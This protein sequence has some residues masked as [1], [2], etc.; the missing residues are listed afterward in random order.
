MDDSLAMARQAHL[1]GIAAIC[2]TPHIRDDHDVR[3]DELPARI[4]ALQ[5][6]L[7]AAAIPVHILAG[8]EVAER[9]AE[10]LDSRTLRR[11]ALGAGGWVL[12]EPRPGPLS[13]TLELL[14]GRLAEE[15]I[16]T[17]IAHP[18]R[19]ADADFAERLRR[20]AAAGCLI[21]WTAEF[22]AQAPDGSP[23]MQLAREGLI[24]LLGSDAHSSHGGRPVRVG[25]A[26][27]RLGGLL[28]E[29]AAAWIVHDAPWAVLR[30][31][32][33]P[34]PPPTPPVSGATARARS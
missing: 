12:I 20:L 8:A 13:D 4:G 34:T 3:I 9:A 24:H 15:G 16:A 18:E 10:D 32:R 17:V 30:G 28:G 1:D 33:P 27:R 7:A 5:A 11:L 19:H 2:A 25:A 21:Q 29:R 31:L 22:V 14:V 6:E 26:A 23:T